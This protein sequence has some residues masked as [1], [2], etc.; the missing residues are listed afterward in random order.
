M[1][2]G[3][4]GCTTT[5]ENRVLGTGVISVHVVPPSI[6]RYTPTPDHAGS[7][8]PPSSP[9]AAYTIDGFDGAKATAPIVS[10]GC[11]FMQGAQ[12]A[13]ALPVRQTP[14]PAAAA[15]T[16]SP[17]LGC[18]ATCATRPIPRNVGS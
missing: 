5:A 9:D 15:T 13:P 11:R 6:D 17:L 10:V 1:T 12:E 4:L 7:Q 14:P 3:R 16:M 18:T 2:S 8:P